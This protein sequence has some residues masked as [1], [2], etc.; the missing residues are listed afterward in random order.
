LVLFSNP[1]FTMGI[2]ILAFL[3]LGMKLHIIV[4][5]M[6]TN[7]SE[8]PGSKN[9]GC[10]DICLQLDT[11]VRSHAYKAP[12]KK[13]LPSIS[14]ATVPSNQYTGLVAGTSSLG[15][16]G[17]HGPATL[18][19]LRAKIPWVDSVG[20][21][22]IPD[23]TN[24]RIRKVDLVGI[25]T[26][27]GGTGT[28]SIAGT[29]GPISSVHFNVPY[30][31]VGD[32]TG[33]IL[34]ISDQRYV[35]KYLFSTNIV[36]VFAHTIGATVGFS[37][38]S[39]PATLAQLNIPKGLWLTTGGSLYIADNTNHRIRKVDSFTG[40]ITTVAGSGGTGSF[41]A[42]G[43]P[44]TSA[45]LSGP[46]GVYMDTNGI[47][48]IADTGNHRIR[49]VDTHNIIITFAGTGIDIPLNGDNLPR[50]SAN[51]NNPRDVKGDSAGNIYIAD[52]GNYVV[53]V[54]DNSG[55]ISVL[56]GTPGYWNSDFLS[57]DPVSRL[58]S[59]NSPWGLWIDSVS[60]VYFSDETAIRNGKF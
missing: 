46:V 1:A 43:G 39:G 34:Y 57:A 23:G 8:F 27:F 37:G 6:E 33:T 36:T 38:D 49:L 58:S 20:N 51:L 7:D 53:R 19:Q 26:T 35:W 4:G 54:V 50:L 32:T 17:D 16:S 42:D 9:P 45:K 3:V 56:F 10:S 11:L 44:A 22:Y 41:S 60:N 52:Y 47:L 24:R 21:V 59:I 31:I 29:G 25:I 55:I 2:M 40:I 13:S 5:W 18:A 28:P 12:S 14:L 48:F 15:Y 30:S